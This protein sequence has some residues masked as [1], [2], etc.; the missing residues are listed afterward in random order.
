MTQTRVAADVEW[1]LALPYT[2][3]REVGLFSVLSHV[4]MLCRGQAYDLKSLGLVKE[5]FFLEDS[6]NLVPRMHAFFLRHFTVPHVEHS[7]SRLAQVLR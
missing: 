4:L 7:V 2:A 3:G 1:A 5:S 6:S